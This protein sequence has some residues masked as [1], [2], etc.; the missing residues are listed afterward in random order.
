LTI[1]DEK[2][3]HIIYHLSVFTKDVEMSFPHVWSIIVTLANIGLAIFLPLDIRITALM[4]R[5]SIEH[6]KYS[7]QLKLFFFFFWISISSHW[8]SCG[9]LHLR[10]MDQEIISG[11]NYLKSLYWTVTTLTSVGYGGITPGDYL[12]KADDPGNDMYFIIKGE[13]EILSK[14]EDKRLT[15]L[16]AGDFFRRDCPV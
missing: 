8:I 11:S 1:P 2:D 16:S 3:Y 10:G 6:L 5:L 7:G 15:R 12:F 9:W 4:K 14:T 13:I